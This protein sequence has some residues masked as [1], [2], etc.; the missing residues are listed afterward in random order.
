MPEATESISELSIRDSDI[1]DGEPSENIIAGSSASKDPSA[2][3][4]IDSPAARTTGWG[5]VPYNSE[6]LFRQEKPMP[7]RPI[8]MAASQQWDYQ[9][10]KVAA[11]SELPEH[12]FIEVTYSLGAEMGDNPN[13]N[14][15]GM[16]PQGAP[17]GATGGL[18]KANLM[19]AEAEAKPAVSATT[20]AQS[21]S[22]GGKGATS[23][24]L[25]A[26]SKD[27]TAEAL[28]A[29]EKSNGEIGDDPRTKEYAEHCAGAA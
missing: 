12:D 2:A 13:P 8:L 22:P 21:T 11:T 14:P 17:E 18:D 29:K 1:S 27:S 7:E 26:D 24:K 9:A 25:P 4:G 10:F 15:D 28:Q 3:A 23:E 5:P 6:P 16:H 19:S 20:K